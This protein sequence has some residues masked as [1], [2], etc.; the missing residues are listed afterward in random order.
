MSIL[1]PQGTMF[2]VLT[3]LPRVREQLVE[4][5]TGSI[6]ANTRLTNFLVQYLVF[7]IFRLFYS[8]N[9]SYYTFYCYLRIDTQIKY[10]QLKIGHNFSSTD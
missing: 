4:V 5:S 9:V 10:G 2:P 8:H 7:A 6:A 3:K 1:N